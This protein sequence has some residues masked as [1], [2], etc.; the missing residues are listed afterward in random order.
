M[1]L[2][3][4][5]LLDNPQIIHIKSLHLSLLQS[6]IVKSSLDEIIFI[7]G[8]LR[9]CFEV[10]VVLLVRYNVEAGKAKSMFFGNGL[11][12][13]GVPLRLQLRSLQ[14]LIY[15]FGF[16]FSEWNS[17]LLQLFWNQRLILMETPVC[18]VPRRS[19]I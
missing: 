15:R 13:N 12:Y 16:L 2:H 6:Y 17:F 10:N 14:E 4:Y 11:Y 8:R 9:M 1:S 7:R 5:N 18:S 3:V 19:L